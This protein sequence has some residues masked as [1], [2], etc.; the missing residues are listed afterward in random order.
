L[1]DPISKKTITKKKAGGVAQSVGLEF[2]TY[3][4]KKKKDSQKHN[5]ISQKGAKLYFCDLKPKHAPNGYEITPGKGARFG[6]GNS[7]G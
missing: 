6:R 7:S 2:K 1:Q 3:T 4:T 5:K